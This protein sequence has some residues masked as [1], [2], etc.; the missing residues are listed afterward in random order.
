MLGEWGHTG[1]WRQESYKGNGLRELA[2]PQE[3]HG[4]AFK[5]RSLWSF[6]QALLGGTQNR[7][8]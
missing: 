2:A 4:L 1:T 6:A 5:R 3:G 8:R 7:A